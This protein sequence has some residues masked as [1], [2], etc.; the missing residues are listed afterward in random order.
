[1]PGRDERLDQVDDLADRL[2]RER[3]AVRPAEAE[4]VRIRAVVFRHL[5]RELVRGHLAFAR[6]DVDLVVDV[7]HVLD[8]RDSEA[9]VL[10][11]ALVEGEDDE[12]PRVPD[13]DPR[14][15]GRPAGVDPDLARLAR[16]ELAEAVRERVVQLDRHRSSIATASAAIPSPRP[17][18][19]RPSFVVPLTLTRPASTP[20]APASRDAIAA[21]CG[22]IRG[23][24]Q[25][26]VAST[27]PTCQPSAVTRATAS[28]SSSMLS[29]PA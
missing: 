24:S 20:S 10:E 28:R 12:R 22:E 27:L 16:L 26:T 15:D 9:L 3:L 25:I 13:M 11:E 7:G 5:A 19:P 14:V 21:A 18:K 23:S 1:M 17:R 6:G 29:A 8:E 4:P 2:A